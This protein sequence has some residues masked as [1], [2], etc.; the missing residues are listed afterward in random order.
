MVPIGRAPTSLWRPAPRPCARRMLDVLCAVAIAAPLWPAPPAAAAPVLLDAAGSHVSSYGGW[1]A[2]SRTDGLTG[3]YELI[4]RSPTGAIEVLAAAERS[5]PFDVELGPRT[6]GAPGPLAV[7]S[8]CAE[9]SLQPECT[10]NSLQL[11]VAG[12]PE[13][14]IAN[15]AHA[16]LAE[17]AFWRGELVYLK[18]VT[19]G[20][21]RLVWQE[22]PGVLRSEPLPLSSGAKSAVG[23]WPAHASGVVTGL[24]MVSSDAITFATRHAHGS[25]AMAGIWL[26]NL[27]TRRAVLI[28]QYTSG[29]GA[30]CTQSF[31]PSALVGGWLYA[32]LHACDPYANPA[33]D[34]WTRYRLDSRWQVT[35]TQVA[36]VS[37][38]RF[39][40]EAIDSV[41]LDGGGVDWSN[42]S[43]VHR[44]ERVTWRSAANHS[45][46]TFCGRHA[47]IC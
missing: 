28:D 5:G 39:G 4:D 38:V 1:S 11:G 30:T 33:S 26:Q 36:K 41:A 25:F 8:S 9:A 19:A 31:T 24:T 22:R 21:E 23:K 34:H 10:I 13:H 29:A 18:S 3:R 37:L 12:A 27:S 40:D 44:L 6:A 7:Y 20:T 45:P 47:P 35:Q 43:G 14:V 2:W 32:Y 42:E 17:P 15:P 16:L 46:E